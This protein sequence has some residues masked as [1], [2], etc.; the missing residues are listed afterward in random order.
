MRN[1]KQFEEAMYQKEQQKYIQKL[2]YKIQSDDPMDE[3]WKLWKSTTP[4]SGPKYR[5]VS[6]IKH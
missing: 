3:N 5:L 2:E 1:I 6:N 4:K